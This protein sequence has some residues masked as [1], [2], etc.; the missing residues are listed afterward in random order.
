MVW[1]FGK[2]PVQIREVYSLVLKASRNDVRHKEERITQRAQSSQRRERQ[3][4]H[5]STPRPDAPEIG[6][7]KKIGPLR[8]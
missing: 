3:K 2:S 5:P 6:A 4:R 1:A 7:K 8:S